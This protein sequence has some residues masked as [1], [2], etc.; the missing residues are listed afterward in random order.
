MR[1]HT[2]VV[3]G[4][5]E[6]NTYVPREGMERDGKGDGKLEQARSA[7]CSILAEGR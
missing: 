5:I 4:E 6:W 7:M 1:I 2:C 3:M